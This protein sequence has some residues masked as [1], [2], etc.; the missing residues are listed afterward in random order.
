MTVF[1]K[2]NFKNYSLLS[3]PADSVLPEDSPPEG[4]ESVSPGIISSAG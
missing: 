2:K 1:S 4:S 3:S